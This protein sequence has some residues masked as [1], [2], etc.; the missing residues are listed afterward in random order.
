MRLAVV[1][2][3]D[4]GDRL[5]KLAFQRPV[6]IVE[7]SA[8]RTA[9]EATSLR[10]SEWPQISVTLFRPLPATPSREDWDAFLAQ[11]A[12]H[13]P[14]TSVDFIGTPLT[15]PLRAALGEAGLGEISEQADGFRARRP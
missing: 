3:P 2:D 8:N 6:W 5:E 15:L 1:L 10:S 14:V 9:A 13:H 7:S 4:F 12:L 11:L